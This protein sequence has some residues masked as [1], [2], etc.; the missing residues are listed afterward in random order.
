MEL[1]VVGRTIE[2]RPFDRLD[3]NQTEFQPYNLYNLYIFIPFTMR[4]SALALLALPALA[5]AAPSN[6]RENWGKEEKH[7]DH[8]DDMMKPDGKK[9]DDLVKGVFHFTSTYTAYA[10]PDQV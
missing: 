7:D 10:G 5:M 2:R 4:V 1:G 6:K 8:H 9:G 3:S